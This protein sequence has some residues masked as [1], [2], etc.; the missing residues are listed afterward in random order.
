MSPHTSVKKTQQSWSASSW[1]SWSGAG[2]TSGPKYER[3]ACP[4]SAAHQNASAM[5]P[6]AQHIKIEKWCD[7]VPVL[8]FNSGRYD[9]NLIREHFAERLSDTTGK[10]RVAKNGNKIMFL[11]TQ[12]FRFLDIINYVGPGTSYEKWTKAY[13]CTAE[14]SWF[15][16]EWF[17][18]PEKLDHPGLPDYPAWY[19]R[20]KGGYV[21]T[22]DEWEGCQRL[23]KQKGMRTFADWLRYYNNL[24]VAPGLGAL[25]RMR[26]FYTEKGIDILMDAVSIP[27]VSLHYL[28]RGAVERGAGPYSPG[29]EAYEMLKGAVVGEPSLVFTWYHEV[30]VTKIR[31]HQKKAEP[32]LCQR[33]LG[34][35]ANALYLSTM[36][37]EMPCEKEKV[38]HYT[39]GWTV[40]AALQLTQRLK[41]RD[42]VRIR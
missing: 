30:R 1:K 29:K 34:Y 39:D 13:G 4:K 22:R 24:D 28:L 6:K 18:T 31:S 11:L 8:G 42:L 40:G 20:L 3:R 23:F 27:G 5:L 19:S 16:H 35:D 14:K 41:K 9:L 36:L 17:D 25:E 10:V 33:I 15:L 37:E 32:R 26:A 38:V 2:K 7:Q 12:E 21:L